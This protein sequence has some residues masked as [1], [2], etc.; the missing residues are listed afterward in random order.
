MLL[1]PKDRFAAGIH[2][3][4]DLYAIKKSL[5]DNNWVNNNK[6]NYHESYR[7]TIL[8]TESNSFV[9]FHHKNNAITQGMSF[10]D[11]VEELSISLADRGEEIYVLI[12]DEYKLIVPSDFLFQIFKNGNNAI[13]EKNDSYENKVQLEDDSIIEIK[14]RE[15]TKGVIEYYNQFVKLVFHTIDNVAIYNQ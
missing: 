6:P 5:K 3:S 4:L 1:K 11:E 14:K 9:C 12:E 7:I 2:L 15:N 13:P 10:Y 8:P